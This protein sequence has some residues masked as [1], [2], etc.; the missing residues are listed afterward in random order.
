MSIDFDC[1]RFRVCIHESADVEAAVKFWSEV[2]NIPES[3]VLRPTLK[4]QSQNKRGRTLVMD[5]TAAKNRSLKSGDLALRI[6]GWIQ[7]IAESLQ[8]E[9]SGAQSSEGALRR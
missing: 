3:S 2:V 8:A 1:L 9:F 4:T 5:I 6:A 7:G